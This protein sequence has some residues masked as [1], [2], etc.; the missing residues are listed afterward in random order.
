MA[1]S[2]QQI[3]ELISN[4]QGM[5]D[6]TVK[7]IS[8]GMSEVN[9]GKTVIEQAG[10]AITTLDE[11]IKSTSIKVEENLQNTNQLLSQSQLLAEAQRLATSIASQ[12]AEGASQAATT[13]E[14][15]MN[16]TQEI[17]TVSA[18]LAKTSAH[19][20]RVIQRFEW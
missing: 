1:K 11:V 7:S 12:F 9:H 18:D 4:V 14:Q 19:L 17:V 16:S 6:T 2:S 5:V 8:Q 13:V 15:Q 3:M 20:H 10:K